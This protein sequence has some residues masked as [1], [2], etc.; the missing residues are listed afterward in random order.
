MHDH[1]MELVSEDPPRVAVTVSMNEAEIRLT[2]DE[3]VSV[4]DVRR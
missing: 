1:G 4:V 2:F 3:A